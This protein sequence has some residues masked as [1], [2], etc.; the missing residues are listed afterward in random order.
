MNLSKYYR[1]SLVLLLVFVLCP[2]PYG[3]GKAS[4]MESAEKRNQLIGHMLSQQLPSIHF[5]EKKMDD[6]FALAA[7][8]LYL[9]QLDYQ[10]RFL[11]AEDVEQLRA[12]A[13]WIDDN[14]V[15]GNIVL[16]QAGYEI[17]TERLGQVEELIAP[18]FK[19]GFDPDR[20]ETL[21]TDPDKLTYKNDMAG[22]K[23][24]WRKIVKRQV[25]SRFLDL[26]ADQE[27]SDEKETTEQLWQKAIK[28]VTK[29]NKDFFH[30][31]HQETLQDHY[32]RYFNAVARAFGPHTNYMPPANKE[33]FDIHM[34]GSLEGI[35][36]LLREEDGYIKIVRIIPGSASARQGR[37]KAEDIILEVAQ[38]KK[39]PVDI[40]DMRLRE[41]VRLIRGPKGSEVRL[42]IRRPDGI[43]ETIPIIRDV[44]QIEETF[45]KSALLD[46]PSGGKIGYIM[47]PSFYRDFAKTRKGAASR[48]STSDTRKALL[49]LKKTPL[50][51]VILDLRNNGGGALMDAVDITGLFIESGPVVQV[52]DSFGKRNVLEDTDPEI[53][54]DGPLVVLVNKFSA[55][56]SEIVAA[57]L[58]DYGRAVIVGGDHTHGKGSVQTIIDLNEYIPMF[59]L[60]RYEDL[61][62]LKIMIQKYYRVTGGSVQ[63][64]G[65]EPDIVLPSLFKYLK[66][67]ERY[68][69]YAL[70]W[71]QVEPVPF[72]R[73]GNHPLHL[74]QLIKKSAER[75]AADQ[76][77]AVISEEAERTS[78]LSEQTAVSLKL[79]DFRRLRQ[80][81]KLAR[82]KIGSHYLKY[83]EEKDDG[84]LRE[85]DE[86]KEAEKSLKKWLEE[87]R[88]DP[89]LKE[90]A[91][92][93][94][95]LIVVQQVAATP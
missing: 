6:E 69:D 88:E 64:K 38:G 85:F 86:K 7:F 13:P 60:R 84:D 26:E 62:A 80:E 46:S 21:E 29:K 12:F 73:Y 58:Q 55:S 59:H 32:D 19:D 49:E 18:I 95:D 89:Y 78:V 72:T 76:S 77:L 81:A 34:R 45:V 39:E 22:L 83:R 79:D 23:Q 15:R 63:F 74:D 56:A 67:G 90:S 51:G 14:L 82:K 3:Y 66:T 36:A 70:P 2:V 54:Y 30:R 27:T 65:V 28:K 94:Q 52:K 35:G 42:G 5:S 8:E 44:V 93:I 33:D 4:K 11:L 31:M 92:I 1:L 16:V 57:A 37:L 24:R 53:V 61:G 20:E 47:I 43:K 68:L 75:V 10:K 41:A 71:D 87:I 17:F 48:N 25:I 91:M 9:K 40:T 50:E